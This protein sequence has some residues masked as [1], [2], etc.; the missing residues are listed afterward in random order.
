MIVGIGD[1]A[2]RVREAS[3][4][5]HRSDVAVRTLSEDEDSGILVGDEQFA[6][7]VDARAKGFIS[8]VLLPA[9]VTIGVALP[10]AP[11]AKP[12]IDAE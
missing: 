9:I 4:L 10:L 5:L 7:R 1:D 2:R 6:T 12:A 11:L 3:D 8:P